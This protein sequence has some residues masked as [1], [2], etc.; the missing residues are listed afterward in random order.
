MVWFDPEINK[1]GAMTN[2]VTR[3]DQAQRTFDLFSGLSESTRNRAHVVAILCIAS[4][5]CVVV[6]S[7]YL[8]G[9]VSFGD[10]SILSDLLGLVS[11]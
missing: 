2:L 10:L 11:F 7:A 6:R 5:T 1:G 3:Q 4:V 9:R 8:E